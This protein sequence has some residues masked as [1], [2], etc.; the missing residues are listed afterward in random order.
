MDDTNRATFQQKLDEFTDRLRARTAEFRKTGEFADIHEALL[1]EIQQRNDA[2]RKRVS[3][4]EAEGSAWQLMKAEFARDFSS[5]YDDLL[6]F[7]YRLDTETMKKNK[8]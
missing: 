6:E 1:K 8:G 5:L 3:E 4:T 2:L 7:E